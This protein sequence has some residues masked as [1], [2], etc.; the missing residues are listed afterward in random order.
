MRLTL[1]SAF[2]AFLRSFFDT[3]V[4]GRGVRGGLLDVTVMDLRDFAEGPYRQIDDYAFGGGGMV[5]QA[6]PLARAVEK[7]AEWGKPFVVGTTPQ[8]VPLT[9]EVVET[10]SAQ[11]HLCLVCGHYEGMDERFSERFVDLEVSIGDY[12]L[13]GG[14]LP[15]LV[16][17]DAVARKI[18]GV[19]GQE[20]AV[21]EDSFFRGFLDHPPYSRPALWRGAEVPSPLLSGDHGAIIAWRRRTAALRT[22]R[23]RPDVLSRATVLPYVTGGVYAAILPGEGP[24]TRDEVLR[25]RRG[26]EAYGL[27]RLGVLAE[28]AETR[29]R[30]RGDLGGMEGPPPKFFGSLG[31]IGR[32]VEEKEGLRPFSLAV[33]GFSLPGALHWLDAKRRMVE[34]DRPGL[35]LFGP[36]AAK[37]RSDAVLMPVRGPGGVV[38]SVSDALWVVLDR[39]FGWR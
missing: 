37:A 4:V 34:E 24:L 16:I 10:L 9:Q 13:T 29:E 6:E 32:W 35:L 38:E 21:E 30:W 2:P 33:P 1:V 15:A 31:Q 12:V 28:S 7:A 22:L 18:P 23:R 39:F 11:E 14:E 25:A 20:S 36:G 3:S 26:C 5:L 27:K 8:G 17:A 19:V